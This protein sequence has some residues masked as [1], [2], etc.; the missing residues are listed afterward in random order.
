VSAPDPHAE[1]HRLR[2]ERG[3]GARRIAMELGISRYAASVLLGRPLPQPVA[4]PDRPVADEVADPVAEAPAEAADGAAGARLLVIDLDLYPGLAE[5]L[6]L[7]QRT[8]A[9]SA[10]AVVNFAVDK[11]AIAYQGALERG[12]L[13]PGQ[14]FDVPRM[15]LNPGRRPPRRSAA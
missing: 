4:E 5:Q 8:G 1:A 2:A 10:A 12:L 9:P 3:W 7:L 13:Q 15:W 14:S 6:A 11:L